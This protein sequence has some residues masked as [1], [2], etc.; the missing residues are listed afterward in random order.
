[1]ESSSDEYDDNEK[2]WVYN[3][4]VCSAVHECSSHFSYTGESTPNCLYLGD[5]HSVCRWCSVNICM[6]CKG[7]MC[8]DCGYTD[9][10]RTR[11][12]WCL[13]CFKTTQSVCHLCKS[14]CDDT[15]SQCIKTNKIRSGVPIFICADCSELI[16]SKT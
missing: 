3:C 7:Q 11:K 6:E 8:R 13:G 4:V 1:M 14:A 2:I 16:T 5:A 9:D 10:R 12:R 15:N